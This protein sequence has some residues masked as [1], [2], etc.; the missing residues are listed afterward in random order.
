MKVG[1]CTYIVVC[2]LIPVLEREKQVDFCE[3]EAIMVYIAS[4]RLVRLNNE[5]LLQTN[6]HT[7]NQTT[8]E[9]ERK[10]W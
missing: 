5:T 9:P 6:K 2:A 3:F 8:N 10:W 7:D 4:S 1:L